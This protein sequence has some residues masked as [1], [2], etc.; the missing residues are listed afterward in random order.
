M[1]PNSIISIV[2]TWKNSYVY[3]L[4]IVIKNGPVGKHWTNNPAMDIDTLVWT[5]WW[6]KY[7][8]QDMSN[9]FRERGLKRYLKKNFWHVQFMF[10]FCIYQC[11]YPLGIVYS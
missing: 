10:Y 4:S 11:L 6:Y 7:S 3:G 1:F 2:D 5:I 8:G 9:I